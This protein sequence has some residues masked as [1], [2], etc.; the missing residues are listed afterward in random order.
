M[1]LEVNRTIRKILSMVLDKTF[2]E[3]WVKVRGNQSSMRF[4]AKGRHLWVN[5]ITAELLLTGARSSRATAHGLRLV[6]SL[7][8]YG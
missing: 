7:V 8:E 3:W 1:T 2:S 6:S 4:G 5:K